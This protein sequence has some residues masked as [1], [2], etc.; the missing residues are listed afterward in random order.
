MISLTI[1]TI[2]V[3]LQLE[4]L[5]FLAG[6]KITV[7]QLQKS[8]KDLNRKDLV[9]LIQVLQ[10]EYSERH[11]ALELYFYS[12]NSIGFRLKD[13]IHREPIVKSF[14]VGKEFNPIELKTLAFVGF[15]QPVEKEAIHDLVGRGSKK[16]INNLKIRDFI[17][18][19]KEE[20][21]VL[22]G[23]GEEIL[24][25]T[26]IFKTT[27]RFAKYFGV[28]NDIDTIKDWIERCM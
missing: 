2:E 18:A 27:E 22:N 12:K 10:Q 1:E 26:D 25:S 24:L 15:F 6:N 14:T 28:K 19:E 16:A 21:L 4:A 20:Y 13:A 17:Y 11:G 5:I 7:D 9:F 3:K 8:F 23:E